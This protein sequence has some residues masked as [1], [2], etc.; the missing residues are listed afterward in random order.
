M[1]IGLFTDTY[2]PQINGV[3]TSVR[4][5]KENLEMFGHQVFVFT[6]TD[7]QA[8]KEEKNVFRVRSFPIVSDRRVGM[9]YQP[10]LARAIKNIG[11][12]I[13]HTHTEF[14]LGIFGKLVARMLHIPLLHTYHTIYEDYTHYIIKKGTMNPF[15]K[16]VAKKMSA[17]FCNSADK[18]IVPT[19]KVKDLL[20]SYG[21]RR[22]ISIIPTGIDLNKFSKA[23]YE[24]NRIQKIRRDLGIG[25]IDQVLL[26]IGRLS[27]E[28]NILEII[29]NLKPYLQKHKH[30]KLVL[31]G[32]GPAR[33]D[34]ENVV[35]QLNLS[36]QII[37]AGEIPWDDIGLYYQLGDVFVSASTSETQGLTYIEALASGLPVLAKEDRC[38]EGV[39]ENN[40]NGYSFI[41]QK[42][43]LQRLDFILQDPKKRLQL[44]EGAIQSTRKF[45]AKYFAL[46]VEKVYKNTHVTV[47][48]GKRYF[49]KGNL[50]VTSRKSE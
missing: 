23:H 26:Y 30:V 9:F 36:K 21:V 18:V 25:S 38:L 22:N 49:R 20:S 24:W 44:S 32:D 1:K 42:E 47:R 39:L 5:L 27:L 4:I 28:K 46:S 14:S 31:V 34:L 37:F 33:D 41:N 15:A 48:E 17:H 3:A 10:Q 50:Q 40:V 11:L 13:I 45:S 16:S 2:Y 43:F 19:D 8:E 12:D 6:T 7:P 35:Q 29:M